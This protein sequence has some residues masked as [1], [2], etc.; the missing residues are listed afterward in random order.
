[1]QNMTEIQVLNIAL[2]KNREDV[3]NRENINKLLLAIKGLEN[4]VFS[5]ETKESIKEAKAFKTNANKF[6]KEF[7]EFCDPLEEEGKTIAKTRS[8]VKL[9]LERIVEN[10]LK[11]IVER[12]DHIKSLK[13]KLFVPSSDINSCNAKLAELVK[14]NNYEWFALKDEAITLINQS[15]VFLENEILGFEKQA[16]EKAEADE[17][18]R[19]EREDQIR[20][21]AILETEAR[22]KKESAEK[23]LEAT[24]PKLYVS[25]SKI[26]NNNDFD[27]KKKIHGEILEALL[28]TCFK[29]ENKGIS[30]EGLVKDIIRSIVN[31]KIPHLQ[32][33]Y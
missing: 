31:G 23:E 14:F 8:E 32:I 10:K 28:N 19:L 2:P 18:A 33:K 27:N 3:S 12:E 1:M 16:K 21:A 25:A 5:F 15:K 30:D 4:N 17:K 7:K 11:P 22:I 20:K 9:T 24:K 13:D 6:I 29:I 26:I